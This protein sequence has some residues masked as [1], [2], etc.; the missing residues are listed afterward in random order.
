MSMNK[1]Y[2]H[3]ELE[4]IM[5]YKIFFNPTEPQSSYLKRLL[6]VKKSIKKLIKKKQKIQFDHIG[7]DKE[8]MATHRAYK[9]K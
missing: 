4:V 5:F 1:R 6:E 2:M 7:G 8:N 3:N 9:I